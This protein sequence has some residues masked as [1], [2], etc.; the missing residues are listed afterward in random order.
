M[1]DLSG[2]IALIT[3][4]SRGMGRAAA[5]EFAKAGAQVLAH[6]SSGAKEAVYWI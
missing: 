6:D 3:G 5:F 4:A 1:S 2:K